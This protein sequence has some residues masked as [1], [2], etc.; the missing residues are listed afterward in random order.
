MSRACL[1]ACSTQGS[2][3]CAELCEKSC[4]L[5]REHSFVVIVDVVLGEL[6][7]RER[8]R[9]RESEVVLFCHSVTSLWVKL[10]IVRRGCVCFY[11]M[12]HNTVTKLIGCPAKTSCYVNEGYVEYFTLEE[13]TCHWGKK[14]AQIDCN[15]G[16]KDST[17]TGGNVVDF[18]IDNTKL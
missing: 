14:T 15:N 18:M 10:Q 12:W 1:C 7:E 3:C 5:Y 16:L 8:E 11:V 17:L 6:T 13:W 2:P 9:Q 4:K